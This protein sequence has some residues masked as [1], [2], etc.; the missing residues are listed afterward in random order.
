MRRGGPGEAPLGSI[1]GRWPY[2]TKSPSAMPYVVACLFRSATCSW[3]SS[4][5]STSTSAGR[6]GGSSAHPPARR[7][8][9]G[10]GP[11]AKAG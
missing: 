1:P 3:F 10:L 11:P 9:A 4:S 6:A 7:G 5:T 8:T 2:L